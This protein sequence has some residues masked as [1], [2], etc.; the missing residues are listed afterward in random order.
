[1]RKILM[2][3][4]SLQ[5]TAISSVNGEAFASATAKAFG[6]GS[7]ADAYASA[8]S[9]GI[10]EHGCGFYQDAFA[11]VKDTLPPPPSLISPL[12]FASAVFL[13]VLMSCPVARGIWNAHWH[14]CQQGPFLTVVTVSGSRK[15]G[16]SS[17]PPPR[18]L[19][20]PLPFLHPS[21]PTN[22][23]HCLA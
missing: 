22:W 1:M 16:S 5:A 21:P 15:Q 18:V 20:S 2:L 6:Q 17:P 9:Q 19:H 12:T 10:Q 4:S 8:I 13:S 11:Q 14:I 23:C 3:L 7:N